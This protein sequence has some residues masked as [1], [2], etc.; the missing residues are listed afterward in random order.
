MQ[1]VQSKPQYGMADPKGWL[2]ALVKRVGPDHFESVYIQEVHQSQG[3]PVMVV[4]ASSLP[5]VSVFLRNHEGSLFA[6]LVEMVGVDFPERERRFEVIYHLLSHRW[7]QRLTLKV[8]CGEAQPI[9]SLCGIYPNADWLEREVYDMYGVIFE[10]HPDLR[11]I[12]TD[13]GF[14]GHPLRKDFPCTGYWD[15]RYDETRKRVIHEPIELAQEMRQFDYTSPWE[16]PALPPRTLTH[17][18]LDTQLQSS[19]KA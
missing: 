13:Y 1:K 18:S 14:Q 16:T 19:S 3:M 5:Y 6:Q 8:L 11:R 4:K 15:V 7:N 12:L 9:P 17:I 2:E 10:G